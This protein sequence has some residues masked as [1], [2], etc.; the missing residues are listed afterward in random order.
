[1]A[2]DPCDQ[3]WVTSNP[4]AAPPVGSRAM[5]WLVVLACAVGACGSSR[6]SLLPPI[7][8]QNPRDPDPTRP[9]VETPANQPP[10][11]GYSERAATAKLG[12]LAAGP[13][14]AAALVWLFSGKP[15]LIGLFGTFDENAA[16]DRS[17]AQRPKAPATEP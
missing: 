13:S 17:A 11:E 12:P 6:L 16:F 5:P 14:A 2:R 9:L 7:S 1:M 15:P 4:S 3:L 10:R 8:T